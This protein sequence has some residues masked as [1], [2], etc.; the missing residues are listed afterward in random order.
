MEAAPPLRRWE[1]TNTRYLLGPAAFVDSLNQQLDA[2]KGRFRIATRFD[3][4]AKTGVDQSVPQSEQVTA[5][6]TTNGQLAVIDFTGALPRAKLYSSWKVSTNEAAKL[7]DWS[8]SIQQRVRQEEA[9]ALAAQ[10]QAD[11]ATLHELAEKEF[12][13]AQTVLLAEQLPVAPGTNQ[14]AG[15]VR[16]E[17]YA[18]KH[19]VLAA[20]ANAPAV[21]LLNDKYDPN[22][23]VTVDGK[24]ASLLRCNFIVRGV[25]L[26]KA[27]EHRVE[28]V[29]QPPLTGLYVSLASIVIALGLIAYVGF[30]KPAPKLA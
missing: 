22:W 29:F 23:K 1:L 5:V 8:K 17:S 24:P 19:I 28:F 10:N 21:L 27:G 12:D 13:P 16:F 3:L 7:Q 20:K 4:A 15:E 11:L 14:N 30:V 2:G 25:F 18:P 9:S 26:E 6:I